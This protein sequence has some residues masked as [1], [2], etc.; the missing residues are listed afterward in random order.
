[1]MD[2]VMGTLLLAGAALALQHKE[3]RQRVALLGTHLRP[4]QL[5]K[6]MEA[7]SRAYL[8]ALDE[9]EPARREQ[10]WQLQA[11]TEL[12]LCAELQRLVDGLAQVPAAQLQ[13]CR[14]PVHPPYATQWAASACFDL[15]ALL[16]AHAQ[17]WRDTIDNPAGRSPK[18]RAYTMMAE[19]LLLQHSCHW[20]CKSLTVASARLLAQHK[21]SHA[22]VLEAVSPPTRA[23]YR[24]ITGY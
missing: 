10:I 1:M 21:T 22:Q 20:F 17:G 7:L 8:R 4:Y 13:V 15:R 11:N 5:E 14:W 3:Q 2:I 9:P 12:Q 18:T 23:A 6:N 16:A 19:M 24:G